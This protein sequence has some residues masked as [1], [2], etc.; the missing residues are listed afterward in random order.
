[1][2]LRF[3]KISNYYRGFLED[4]QKRH[5]QVKTWGYAQQHQHLMGQYF[6]WSDNYGRLLAQ[7]GLE[8][9][10][11]VGNADWMQHA[12]ALENGM[13]PLASA[14]EI[15][16]NQILKYNPEVIYFQDSMTYNGIFVSQLRQ[17]LPGLKLCI[18]NLCAPFGSGQI[19]HFKAFDYFTVCSPFFREQLSRFGIDS[20]V[21]PHAFDGRILPVIEAGNDYPRS[22][23]I[24]LGSVFADE[25]FHS[26]RR[27]ILENLVREKLPFSFYGNLPDRSRVALWKKQA[28]FLASRLLDTMGLK[29][30]TDSVTVFR[31]GRNHDTMPRGL[32]LSPQLYQMAKAPLFG[33][34]MFKALAHAEVGFNIHI[35]CAGDYAANMRLFETT[36]VGTCLLTDRKSNLKAL[37]LEDFEV[38]AYDSVSECMEKIKWLMDHPQ[39]REAIARQGQQKTLQYHNFEARVELF[40]ERMRTEIK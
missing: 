23:L 37:F 28:S 2:S 38:V 25:G 10:E 3:L 27:E 35:D 32:K 26:L 11:I 34:D 1:M 13:R 30:V 5:P 19:E 39:E 22:P 29:G 24:F 12:W 14:S 6:A 21:I 9:M 7:Q 31:K 17:R 4:Y 16:L 36:G 8:T 20:V 40:Y 15:L 18:G 33:L